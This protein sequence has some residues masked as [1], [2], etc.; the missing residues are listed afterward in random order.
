MMKVE[1]VITCM[2]DNL[3]DDEI[4]E[5]LVLLPAVEGKCRAIRKE[6][7]RRNQEKEDK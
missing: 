2:V 6:V 1:D 5:L 7:D 3:T 4:M